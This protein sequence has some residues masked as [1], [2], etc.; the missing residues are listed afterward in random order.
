MEINQLIEICRRVG[1]VSPVWTQG[2]G[3]NAS[4][5]VYGKNGKDIMLIKASGCRL[6]TV[7][8]S[9]GLAALDLSIFREK[10]ST[11]KAD[12]PRAELDY[13]SCLT[14]TRIESLGT[15]GEDGQLKLGKP[16]MESG[17][18]AALPGRFVI[19]F[20]SLASLVMYEQGP[21]DRKT[22]EKL[23]AENGVGTIAW[24]KATMPGLTL[25]RS[26]ADS[27]SADVFILQ[28]HG[29]ILQ[30]DRVEIIDRWQAF[31]EKWAKSNNLESISSAANQSELLKSSL[32]SSCPMRFYFPDT[33]VFYNQLLGCLLKKKVV[34]GEES[35]FVFNPEKLNEKDMLEIW[36][37]TVALF[38][39]NS[40]GHQLPRAI[41]E[42][43]AGL[44][45]EQF[46]KSVGEI[47]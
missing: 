21:D 12:S 37:A 1:K 42:N 30:S 25:S 45:V 22:I 20:H 18:H 39:A 46:R 47:K 26:I 19:H 16:S 40:K 41:V 3:G 15:D 38:N 6:D 9:S 14:A 29:V 44:P 7:S 34:E 23:A 33:A 24:I 4:C 36:S 5:K 32:T 28:N 43:V 27:L 13:A 10:F 8:V 31:E 17:F 2:A 35:L 11:I